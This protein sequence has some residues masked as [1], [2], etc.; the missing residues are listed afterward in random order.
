MR[1]SRFILYTALAT[2]VC[3][4]YVAQ[5]TEIVKL[6]YK[7]TAAEKILQATLDRRTSL[8]YTLTSLESPLS[9][10]KQLLQQKDGYEMAQRYKFVKVDAGRIRKAS[11]AKSA[12]LAKGASFKRLAFQSFF[13]GK[14]AEA[15]TIP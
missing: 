10:D 14:S 5:Q 3:I 1:T 15:K 11:S 8:E 13:A 2:I 9:L 7:I 4:L 12:R 6:G